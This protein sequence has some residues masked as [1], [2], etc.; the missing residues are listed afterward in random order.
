MIEPRCGS[1]GRPGRRL[2]GA[3]LLLAAAAAAAAP[4]VRAQELIVLV[5]H[6]EQTD[7]TAGD[8]PLSERGEARAAA[9]AALLAEAGITAVYS[10][11]RARA[12]ATAAPLAARIGAEIRVVP[13]REPEALLRR[14]RAEQADG[15]V[16]IVGH[17]NTVPALLRL[18]GH[19][20]EGDLA[21]ED[22]DNVFVIRPA[23]EPGGAPVV[24]RLRTAPGDA[25]PAATAAAVPTGLVADAARLVQPD[26]DARFEALTGILQERGLPFT[27]QEFPGPGRGG[28]PRPRGRNV[29]VT[30]GDGPRDLVVGAHYDAVR[31]PDGTLSH[32]MVDNGAGTIILTRV[33]EA[34]RDRLAAGGAPLRHRVRVVFFDMEEIGLVGSRHYASGPDGAR[35]AAMVNLDVAGYGDAVAYGP[36]VHEGNDAVYAAL[37]RSCA[38]LRARCVELPRYPSSDDRSFQAAGIPNVSLGVMQAAEVHQLWLLLNAGQESGLRPDFV[39]PA[40]RVIHTPQDTVERLEEEAL[41]LGWRVVL[42]LVLRLDGELRP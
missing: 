33:A 34:L 19:P 1:W 26:N 28:D 35:A 10:S 6:A 22:F 27:V 40:L 13:A 24:L 39:P 30:I 4:P 37:G 2:A 31:L 15:R 38:A 20:H 5:R 12:Q 36:T 11:E 8:P 7:H 9:L 41:Q 25:A 14:V 32:G 17:S 16:L 29:I 18:L 23:P 21:R 42:D 3:A